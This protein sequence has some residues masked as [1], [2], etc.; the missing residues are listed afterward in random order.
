MAIWSD[1]MTS[2]EKTN[3]ILC[4]GV[5]VIVLAI[6]VF[7]YAMRLML[8]AEFQTNE[9][10]LIAF[11]HR[12]NSRARVWLLVDVI[13]CA[14]CLIPP[15]QSFLLFAELLPLVG[16]ECYLVAKG[17]FRLQPASAVR[18]LNKVKIEGAAK[19]VLLFVCLVT[20]VVKILLL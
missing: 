8:I 2:S 7:F 18:G 15:I 3:D 16:Y 6:V 4:L 19:L 17:Q 5:L 1:I 11:V 14:V 13:L 9:L 12:Y 20:S 10:S